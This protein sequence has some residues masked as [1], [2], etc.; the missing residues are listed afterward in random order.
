MGSE[1][2]VVLVFWRTATVLQTRDRG[3]SPVRS[4][5]VQAGKPCLLK[6]S[7]LTEQNGEEEAVLNWIFFHSV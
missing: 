7:G 6:R 2:Q 5:S 1:F 4:L 3:A